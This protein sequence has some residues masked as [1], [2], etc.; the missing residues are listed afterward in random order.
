MS[1]PFDKKDSRFF[2]LTNDQGQ[3]SL[4]PSF[5]PIPDGWTRRTEGTRQEC[6]E[7]IAQNWVD[8]RPRRSVGASAAEP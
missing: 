8:I 2:V 3:H 1:N 5:I 4:W 6:L 7:Y